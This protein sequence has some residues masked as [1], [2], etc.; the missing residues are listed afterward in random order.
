M[1]KEAVLIQEGLFLRKAMGCGMWV[2]RKAA[3]QSVE[4]SHEIG[5]ATE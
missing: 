4:V 5:F 1:E 2:C 3:G